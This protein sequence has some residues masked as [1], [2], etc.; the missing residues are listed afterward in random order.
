MRK[1]LLP[2]VASHRAVAERA[3][4]VAFDLMRD[5]EQH[6]DLFDLS[7]PFRHA[8]QYAPHPSGALAAGC[9]LAATFVLVKI[10]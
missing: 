7:L 5:F 8:L 4:R 2:N 9:T 1:V 3:N 10:S 6:V